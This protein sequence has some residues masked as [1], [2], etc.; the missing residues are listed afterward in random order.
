MDVSVDWSDWQSGYVISYTVPNIHDID[1]RQGN[2]DAE[3][4]YEY[5]VESRLLDDLGSLGIGPELIVS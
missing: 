5:G 4:F 3:G 1:A 2:S